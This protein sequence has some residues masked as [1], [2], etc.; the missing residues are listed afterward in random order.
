MQAEHDHAEHPLRPR[1]RRLEPAVVGPTHVGV[2]L[3]G[4][5]PAIPLWGR[6]IKRAADLVASTVGIIV[7]LPVLAVVAITVRLDSPGPSLFVQTRVGRDGR[8]FKCL[9]FRTMFVDNDDSLHKEY[10]AA[11]IRGDGVD[12]NGVFKLTEDPRIT[13]VGRFL[14]RFSLDELPQLFNVFAGT[15]TL[16]GPRPAI[17]EE[18][19]LYDDTAWARLRVKPGL[20]GLWQVSGRCELNFWQMVELDVA[21]W[22]QWTPWLDL[23]ILAR[24]PK[25]VFSTRGAA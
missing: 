22:R 20:T 16:I 24:T 1:L 6:A 9:K 19:E 18:T 4:P 21:Y 13:R 12:H 7:T 2:L 10:V 3:D 15:M 8:K 17:P 5:A 25:A 14:R 23:R 11:L